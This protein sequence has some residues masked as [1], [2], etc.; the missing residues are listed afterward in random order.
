M[1]KEEKENIPAQPL[2]SAHRKVGQRP[3]NKINEKGQGS[4]R[5]IVLL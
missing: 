1:D 5:A 4:E 3:V 2:P